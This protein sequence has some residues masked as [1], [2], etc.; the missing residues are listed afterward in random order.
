[1]RTGE[2][3]NNRWPARPTSFGYAV[4]KY[5]TSIG[6]SRAYSKIP[7]SSADPAARCSI[8]A[9][10]QLRRAYHSKLCR[11]GGISNRTRRSVGFCLPTAKANSQQT[12]THSAATSSAIREGEI[13][14]SPVPGL[15]SPGDVPVPH[16]MSRSAGAVSPPGS[17]SLIHI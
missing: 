15:E 17:L 13:G 11:D 14:S 12:S 3:W 5:P 9:P 6:S 4:L 2:P 16:A 8:R 10:A 1:M 7:R